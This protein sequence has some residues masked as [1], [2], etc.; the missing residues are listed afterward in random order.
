MFTV[1]LSTELNDTVLEKLFIE[2][3]DTIFRSMDSR[4]S[5]FKLDKITSKKLKLLFDGKYQK[6][7]L[8]YRKVFDNTVQ[9]T[10][11]NSL[12]DI[13]DDVNILTGNRS[14]SVS[15]PGII[16]RENW[17]ELSK[18]TVDALSK[19]EVDDSNDTGDTK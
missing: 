3:V 9:E 14:V 10:I 5:K 16:V 7:Y 2:F 4:L 12:E 8:D 17:E 11:S 15:V 13:L 1:S 6:V 19:I 18:I